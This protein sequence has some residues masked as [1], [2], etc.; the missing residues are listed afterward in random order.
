VGKPGTERVDAAPV[1]V[2]VIQDRL[3]QCSSLVGMLEEG[4]LDPSAIVSAGSLAEGRRKLTEVPVDVVVSELPA[5]G[6]G[7]VEP[8]AV[9]AAAAPGAAIVAVSPPP[10]TAW[11]S[12]AAASQGA[13]EYLVWPEVDPG[14][15]AGAVHRAIHRRRERPPAPG[16]AGTAAILDGV[17]ALAVV[18]DGCGQILAV[19][20]QWAAAGQR[21][22]ASAAS[23]G[24]GIN[25]LTVCDQATGDHAEGARQVAEGIRAVLTGTAPGFAHDYPFRDG[26]GERWF[27]VRVSATSEQGGAALVS[28]LDVT[29]VKLAE[30]RLGRQDPLRALLKSSAPIFGLVDGE[31]RVRHLSEATADRLGVAPGRGAGR[32]ILDRLDP[33][34]REVLAATLRQAQEAPGGQATAR[35]GYRDGGGRWRLFDLSVTNRLDQ[36]GTEA[37]VVSGSDV[38]LAQQER[39]ARQLEKRA[40]ESLPAAVI[41]TDD[42]GVVAYWNATATALY[43][44]SGADAVGRSLN[45]LEVRPYGELET[46]LVLARVAATG[47]WE[48]ECD[49]L[50]A[51]GARVPVHATL[52]RIDDGELGFCGVVGASLDITERRLLERSLA[53]QAHHDPVT[54][55]PNRRKFLEHLDA[56]LTAAGEDSLVAV[57]FIDLDDF[58]SVND[59][60]GHDSADGVLRIIGELVAGVLRPGDLVARLG[61]D[62]FAVCCDNLAGPPEATAIAQRIVGA[63]SAP[64]RVESQTV[65]VTASIGIALSRS[66]SRSEELL[67]DADMAMYEAKENGKHRIQLFE[68]AFRAEKRR[69]RD[70][71]VALDGAIRRGE[72]ATY[73]QPQV[74]LVT[75]ALYGFEALVRW[76]SPD[77]GLL[78]PDEFMAAAEGSGLIDQLGQQV[79]DEACQ[80][81]AIWAAMAP[82]M[83]LTVAVNFSA[84]QLA[85]GDVPAAVAAAITKAQLP[86]EHL[87]VE[88]TESGLGEAEGVHRVVRRL[89]ELGVSL[90]IDDFGAG[91]SSLSRLGRLPLDFLKID[92]SFVTAMSDDPAGVSIIASII[93]LARNLGLRTIAEGVETRAQADQLLEMGCDLAQGWLWS[94]AVDGQQATAVLQRARAAGRLPALDAAAGAPTGGPAG[95]QDQLPAGVSAGT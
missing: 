13:D 9:L 65:S 3:S 15:L 80:A 36:P 42:R 40:L 23:I 12:R 19:N 17:G 75:G 34:D 81:L 92:R 11:A 61:G 90:A 26:D 54:D 27:T 84:G 37:L 45:E 18:V 21:G 88:I 22:G 87:C 71:I 69:R 7:D 44:L 1:A 24:V 68:E 8:V 31:G 56:T 47:Q 83:P 29:A 50:C 95:R 30:D 77:R 39:L 55:L 82:D 79:L 46:E 25:Y 60:I 2:L 93:G 72:M 43:G 91:Y 10:V 53:Y 33:H 52:R 74:S 5:P 59:R 35:V 41:V 89:R 85:A 49:A 57:M 62:E 58:K 64:F 20:R 73:F 94:P 32:S 51:D 4:G 66:G 16:G 48:G 6:A 38:T 76:R 28:H 78:A 63:L 86:P 14:A 67:R 70:M